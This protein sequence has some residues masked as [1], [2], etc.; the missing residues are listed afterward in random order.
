MT[1]NESSRIDRYLFGEMSEAEHE[2]FEAKLVLDDALFYS[3]ADRENDL[4][5]RYVTNKLPTEDAERFRL[6]L[7][8]FAA[9][10]QKVSNA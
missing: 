10:Q 5:D 1:D 4:V 7:A 2:N 6:S 9:R 3:I 8:K